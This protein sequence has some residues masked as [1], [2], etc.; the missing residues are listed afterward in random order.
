MSFHSVVSRRKPWLLFTLAAVVVG[1][2]AYG[3][4]LLGDG[5][6]GP[7]GP[8]RTVVAE[9]APSA[10]PTAEP[11]PP[12]RSP[13]EKPTVKP[14]ASK[15]SGPTIA[16]NPARAESPVPVPAHADGCDHRYGTINDCVPWNFPPEYQTYERKCAYL[17][18]HD[19]Q[20]VAVR[21]PDRHKI[22]PNKNG[23]A[24]DG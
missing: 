14:Y 5:G 17:A 2:L 3:V 15:L 4:L 13:S 20:G 16:P 7:A 19:Y 24:C 18:N 6:S 22:D 23:V 9:A 12:E 1:A 8:Q 21:P 10:L 11:V